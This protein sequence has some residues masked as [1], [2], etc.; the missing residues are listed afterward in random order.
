MC[1]IAY[2]VERRQR[3]KWHKFMVKLQSA[4]DRQVKLPDCMD[5]NISKA[6]ISYPSEEMPC[7]LRSLKTK[8]VSA[9]DMAF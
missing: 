2:A 3:H 7:I 9:S 8:I 4:T 6:I 5:Q 1:V